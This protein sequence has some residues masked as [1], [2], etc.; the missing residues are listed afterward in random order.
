MKKNTY[1]STNHFVYILNQ[2]RGKE[3]PIIP[4][5]VMDI[6]VKS[7]KDKNIKS[8]SF[9]DIKTILKEKNLIIYYENIHQIAIKL[10]NPMVSV[11]A[12]ECVI[13]Y[14]QFDQLTKLLCGHQFCTNCSNKVSKE[15]KIICPLCRDEQSFEKNIILTHLDQ[16]KMIDYFDK[17][18]DKYEIRKGRMLPFD[19]IIKDVMENTI[20]DSV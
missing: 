6:I 9:V 12:E 7:L 16:H 20:N 2:F 11:N 17:N 13:C 3:E 4:T 19:L 15:N 5:Y 18:K 10:N 1:T 8:P 14:E